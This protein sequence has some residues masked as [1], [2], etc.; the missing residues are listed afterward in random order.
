[1]AILGDQLRCCRMSLAVQLQAASRWPSSVRPRAVWSDMTHLFPNA[2]G[3]IAGT[4]TRI[5]SC[6]CRPI[7]AERIRGRLP[8]GMGD[9]DG[10]PNRNRCNGCMYVLGIGIEIR[11]GQ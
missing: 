2:G 6:P 9:V 5:T 7:V 10:R 8:S 3:S 1:M 11:I 4:S